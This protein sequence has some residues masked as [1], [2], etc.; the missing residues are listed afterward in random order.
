VTPTT[1]QGYLITVVLWGLFEGTTMNNLSDYGISD[2][3]E[4]VSSLL[5]IS[6]EKVCGKRQILIT[7]PKLKFERPSNEK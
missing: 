4:V 1:P 2:T 6:G 7:L 5:N 3:R